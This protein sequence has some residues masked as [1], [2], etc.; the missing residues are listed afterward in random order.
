M[1]HK[2][3]SGEIPL[4]LARR[5]SVADESRK[6][7][8]AVYVRVSHEK[9]LFDRQ[10]SHWKEY[11]KSHP[12]YNCVGIYQEKKS[13]RGGITRKQLNK[14]IKDA[15]ANRFKKAFF[16]EASRLGRNVREA[17][18]RIEEL[19]DYGVDVYVANINQE[20]QFDDP[21]S[22]LIIQ[23]M[24]IFAE[25]ESALISERTT[26]GLLA[27]NEKLNAWGATK[28]LQ[29]LRVG[30]P[31]ILED[32]VEDPFPREGKRGLAVIWSKAKEQ[33]F[34]D[35]WEG[36]SKDAYR[37]IQEELRIAVSPRCPN[38]CHKF[39]KKG[40]PIYK[41]ESQ[42][43]KQSCLC[44]KRPSRKTVHKTRVKLGLPVRNKHSFKRKDIPTEFEDIKYDGS[45]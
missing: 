21:T 33:K 26:G 41:D 28:G 14:L 32:W 44:G 5:G 22:R 38:K 42:Y 13:A 1:F 35:I 4:D 2:K 34:R 39:D 18:Q 7:D 37:E 43:I 3:T 8:V 19:H 24:L 12:E 36:P 17:L 29:P 6:I 27:K 11:F 15:K 9:L 25:F 30:T 40:N 20:Y 31:S 45:E 10:M 23:Q 16:W